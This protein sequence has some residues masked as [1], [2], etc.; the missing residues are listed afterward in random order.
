[1]TASPGRGGH[2]W[3]LRED[4]ETRREGNAP[5]PC[6]ASPSPE[7]QLGQR[8]TQLSPPL[9]PLRGVCSW[10]GTG[11]SVGVQCPAL[12][13]AAPSPPPG[14][15]SEGKRPPCAGLVFFKLRFLLCSCV[16]IRRVSPRHRPVTRFTDS[17]VSRVVDLGSHTR[18]K[19]PTSIVSRECDR[20]P[21]A[22]ARRGAER[23]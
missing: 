23:R 6:L 20:R 15:P 14:T 4:T 10:R 8:R 19:R 5:L 22:T 18:T 9:V 1:M 2:F 7:R 3:K 11:V 17:T 21:G 12:V 16:T 13:P